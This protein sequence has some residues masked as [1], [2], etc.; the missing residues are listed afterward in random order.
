MPAHGQ[1]W[2]SRRGARGASRQIYCRVAKFFKILRSVVD[3]VQNRDSVNP[4]LTLAPTNLYTGLAERRY[5]LY[6][7][8]T[9]NRSNMH[10][11][12]AANPG[13]NTNQISQNFGESVNILKILTVRFTDSRF[14][15]WPRAVQQSAGAAEGAVLTPAG[16]AEGR[17]R[18]GL[19]CHRPGLLSS[20]MVDDSA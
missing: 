18:R 2:T 14:D 9:L 20:T 1:G 5:N 11:I 16:A 12:P 4:V 8:S 15:D 7:L 19:F 17:L 6:I 13:T 10:S 3:R